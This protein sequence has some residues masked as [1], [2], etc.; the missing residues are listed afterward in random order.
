MKV[1]LGGGLVT[2]WI[3]GGLIDEGESFGGLADAAIAGPGEEA[4]SRLLGSGGGRNAEPLGLEGFAHVRYFAPARI[5]PYN[6]S[7]GCPWKRCTFCPEKAENMPYI[8]LSAEEATARVARIAEDW[9]PG[10]FHFTDSEIAPIHLEALAASPPPAPWYGFARFSSRLLDRRFCR[11]LAASGCVM[12]QLGLESGDQALLDK[13][14][15][16]TKVDEIGIILE[17]LAEA[18][19]GTYVYVLFGTP[20]EDR[21]SAL[22]TRDFVAARADRIDFLNIAI[23]NLPAMSAEAKRLETRSFFEGDL[24]LYKDFRHPLGWDRS[25]V[26]RFLAEDFEA[27]SEIRSIVNRTPPVFSSNHA[28]FFLDS[29]RLRMKPT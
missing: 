7:S 14:G 15:K 16:G 4:L 24:T 13:L 17:N 1:A 8:G 18:G 27:V 12:L 11:S 28:P 10:L 2:S 3:A 25:V 20:E 9:G 29:M 19:I 5:V 26:R 6:F 23:F 21:S 22:R